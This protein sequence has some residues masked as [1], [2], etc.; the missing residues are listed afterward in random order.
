MTPK[1]GRGNPCCLEETKA[2]TG[3]A[4]GVAGWALSVMEDV[5]T[6]VKIRLTGEHREMIENVV[7]KLHNAPCPN[8]DL[9]IVGRNY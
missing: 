9:N 1:F 6:D 7:R 8:E 3:H 5:K 2:Q 4:Y